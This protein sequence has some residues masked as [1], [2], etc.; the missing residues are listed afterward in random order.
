VR[1]REDF[2]VGH[3]SS[4]CSK[5]STLNPRVLS[6]RLPEKKIY[7]GG[8]S[9]LSILLSLKPGCHTDTIMMPGCI[10]HGRPVP[11]KYVVVE[12]SM[13]KEGCEFEDLDYPNEEKGI[14]KLKDAKRNFI[15]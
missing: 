14:E 11:S 9:I 10:I 6:V 15:L 7:L 8:M 2:S 4:N 5:P 13:I 1:T 12:M 3:P